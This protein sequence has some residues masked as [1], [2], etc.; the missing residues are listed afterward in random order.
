MRRYGKKDRTSDLSA[1]FWAKSPAELATDTPKTESILRVGR[2]HLKRDG[3]RQK[4]D[5]SDN[6]KILQVVVASSLW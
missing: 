2:E 5:K 3:G 1:A 6:E 4:K